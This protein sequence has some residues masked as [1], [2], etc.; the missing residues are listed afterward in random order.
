MTPEMSERTPTFSISSAW[1][2]VSKSTLVGWKAMFLL[3]LAAATRLVY[4]FPYPIIRSYCC[5][6]MFGETLQS[7]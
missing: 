2:A 4:V 6:R 7:T 1:F 5:C 3:E